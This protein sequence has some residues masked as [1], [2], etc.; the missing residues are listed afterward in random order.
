MARS[1]E[2]LRLE[3]QTGVKGLTGLA[4]KQGIGEVDM[5]KE[6]LRD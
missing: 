4:L 3:R 5:T 1:P 6:I 2:V